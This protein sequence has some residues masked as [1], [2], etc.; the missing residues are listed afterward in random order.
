MS[1]NIEIQKIC[2][3]CNKKFIAKTTVTKFCSDKCSKRAYKQRIKNVR[4][5]ESNKD[6]FIQ[7]NSTDTS[8]LK[9]KE[10][11]TPANAALLLGV[12]RATMYR[13]LADTIIK[14]VVMRG[15]TFIRRQDI[16]TLFDK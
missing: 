9:Y 4:I 14:C 8:I 11:L 1:S 10:Y 7:L 5:D 3:F 12:S 13:Y 2:Q 16:E 15:K 6:T